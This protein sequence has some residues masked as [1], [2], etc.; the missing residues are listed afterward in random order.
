MIVSDDYRRFHPKFLIPGHEA[1]LQ[2][3]HDILDG[4]KNPGRAHII[5]DRTKAI[6]WAL[7]EA[8]PGDTV[9]ITGKGDEAFQIVGESAVRFDD[10]Q[11]ARDWLYGKR[12]ELA[13]VT[14]T[15]TVPFQLGCEWN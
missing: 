4:F 10:R 1:P 13:D 11:V 14:S 7:G 6:H 3:A 5:P 12:P 2:I 9:L 8:E 15:V